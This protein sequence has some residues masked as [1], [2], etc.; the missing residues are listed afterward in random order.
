[1]LNEVRLI[2]RLGKNPELRYT[3]SGDAVGEISL[4]TSERFK[5]KDGEAQERTEWHHIV[6]WK[7]L[8]ETCHKFLT[9]GKLVFVAGKI[10]TR[11]YDDRDGNKR[12]ITEIVADQ[13]KFLDK[14]ED[15]AWFDD[16]PQSGEQDQRF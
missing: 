13:V 1:M 7:G 9:K 4:A 6:A 11:S 14:V 10:K 3:P 5:A 12:Y 2:G 8:A 15:Q 16:P